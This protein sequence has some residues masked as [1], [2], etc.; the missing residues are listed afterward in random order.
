MARFGELNIVHKENILNIIPDGKGIIPYEKII[1]MN[2]LDIAPER[3]FFKL[4]EFYSSLKQSA[5][6]ESDYESSKFLFKKL[7]MRNIN[8]MNDLNNMQDV[9]LLTE[10]IE[11]RFEEMY[12]KYQYNPRK[13]NSAST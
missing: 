1:D 9:I 11:N 7:K 13:C 2:S 6:N 12:K 10:I 3:D 8:D 5:V 4:T